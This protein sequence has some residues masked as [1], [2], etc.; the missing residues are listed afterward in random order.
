MAFSNY[1]LK[2]GTTTINDPSPSKYELQSIYIDADSERNASG[3]LIRNVVNKKYK[4]QLEFPP[5]KATKMK[6]LLTLLDNT[7]MTVE[8]YDQKSDTY[9]TGTFYAGD[10]I[11]SPLFKKDEIV[12][13]GFK[14][15]LIEY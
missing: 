15:N 14:I 7:S 12:Y 8:Y 11:T 3:N 5:M 2:I 6:A 1:Y 4:I 13:D 10:L 9:R